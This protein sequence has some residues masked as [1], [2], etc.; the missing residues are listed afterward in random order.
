MLNS[1]QKLIIIT[2]KL[3]YCRKVLDFKGYAT[4]DIRRLPPICYGCEM[5]VDTWIGLQYFLDY[6]YYFSLYAL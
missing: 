4:Y 1:V 2:L 5:R 6:H 3:D